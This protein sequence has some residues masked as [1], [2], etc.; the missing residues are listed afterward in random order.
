MGLQESGFK[1]KIFD[2]ANQSETGKTTGRESPSLE[3]IIPN[4]P[5]R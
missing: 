1:R 3:N 5:V 2:P 4:H